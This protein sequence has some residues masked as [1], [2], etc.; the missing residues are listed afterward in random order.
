MRMI[1][2]NHHLLP[3]QAISGK[4]KDVSSLTSSA[5][6]SQED[7]RVGVQGF[8]QLHTKIPAGSVVLA[9]RKPKGQKARS[10]GAVQVALD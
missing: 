10:P 1:V 4:G 6:M 9:T 7:P 2:V 3:L 8:V 5:V